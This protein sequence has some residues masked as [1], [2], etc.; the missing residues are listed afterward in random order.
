MTVS[1]SSDAVAPD[2]GL[3]SLAS[4]SPNAPS[5]PASI[6]TPGDRASPSEERPAMTLQNGGGKRKRTPVGYTR[7]K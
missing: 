5:A 3:P 6:Q 1:P 4:D 2:T 7:D